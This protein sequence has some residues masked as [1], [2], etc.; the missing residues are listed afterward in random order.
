[1]AL[2]IMR[3]RVYWSTMRRDCEEFSQKCKACQLYGTVSHRPTAPFSTSQSPC[4]FSMWGIDLVGPLPKCT[5]QKQFL[6]VAI[7][8]YTKWPEARPLAMIRETDVVHFFMESIVFRFGVPRTVVKNN[9]SQFTG[10]D[11][12]EVLN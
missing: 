1:M 11:F 12:K 2:K 3:H 5:G 6:I 9:G 8:Y 10:K 4:P 7:D